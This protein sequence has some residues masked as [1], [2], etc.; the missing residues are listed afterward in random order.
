[1]KNKLILTITCIS[2]ILISCGSSRGGA[3]SAEYA[4]ML[5]TVRELEFEIENDWANPTQY[6]RVN[7][8]GNPN[9]IRFENDSVNVYLP[10]FGERYSGGGYN[11]DGGAIQFKGVP[12]ELTIRENPEKGSVEVAF[13]GNRG[14]ESFDFLITIFPNGVAYTSVA[15]SQRE[16]IRYD[17][18]VVDLE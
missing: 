1:M 16:K 6:P 7:L 17:G 14:T 18:N 13:E 10:F 9:F 5:E 12:K 2:M 4:E 15:S 11:S 8:T 3:D